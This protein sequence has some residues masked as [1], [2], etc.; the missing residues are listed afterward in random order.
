MGDALLSALRLHGSLLVLALEPTL[1]LSP[2]LAL[3]WPFELALDT[4]LS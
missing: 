2:V 4:A 1:C 3:I